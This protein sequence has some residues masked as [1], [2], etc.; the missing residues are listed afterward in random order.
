MVK[1]VNKSGRL[2]IWVAVIVCSLLFFVGM[3]FLTGI[4]L[5]PA[6]ELYQS[7]SWEQTDAVMDSAKVDENRGDDSTSYTPNVSY[8]YQVNG[9]LYHGSLFWF[10]QKN[11][12]NK[13]QIVQDALDQFPVGE[14][15][16]LYYNPS[17][18][19]KSVVLRRLAPGSWFMGL[20]ASFFVLLPTIILWTVF[21]STR[22]QENGTLGKEKSIA[23][24]A[25]S[26]LVSVT[27][28]VP[29]H[30]PS[31]PNEIDDPHDNKPYMVKPTTNQLT[32]AII[33]FV[34]ALF[35]IGIT[36]VIG[37]ANLKTFT[38]FSGLFFSLF[39]LAGVGLM[40]GAVYA[41]LGSLNPKAT[42]VCSQSQIYPGS[43]FEISW[44]FAGKTG[45]IRSI[46]LSLT[47]NETV[48]YRAGTDTRT[49]TKAFLQQI[50]FESTDPTTFAEGFALTKVPIASMHTFQSSNNRVQWLVKLEGD[51]PYWPNLD[52]TFEIQVYPPPIG[53]SALDPVL[54][55]ASL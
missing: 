6:W 4:Y 26:P 55:E 11:N 45:R 33:L 10:G 36:S 40:A 35:W 1:R 39:F 54:A 52:E 21:R 41:F 25:V 50:L 22:T 44:T 49:E 51:I 28:K 9:T 20:F 53:A 13:R 15:F 8:H 38:F 32:T 3:G 46:K 43:E 16:G 48:T 24:S 30:S 5:Y 34:V 12:V 47:G 2:G 14:E 31:C 37:F 17:N 42:V 29:F 18:P 23:V 7:G 19:S 27:S